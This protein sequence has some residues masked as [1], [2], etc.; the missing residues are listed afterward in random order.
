MPAGC[1][2]AN[3]RAGRSVA[4]FPLA[5]TPGALAVLALVPLGHRLSVS[6]T[7]AQYQGDFGAEP[8]LG[9]PLGH[10]LVWMLAVLAAGIA[11]TLRVLRAGA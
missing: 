6:A 7:Y 11:W 2:L 9:S 10:A 1:A 4:F 3:V 8:I 5:A